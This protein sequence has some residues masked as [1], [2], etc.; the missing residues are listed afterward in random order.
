VARGG[1]AASGLPPR[2]R[3]VVGSSRGDAQRASRRRDR[4]RAL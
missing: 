2:A 4:D 3:R 1:A